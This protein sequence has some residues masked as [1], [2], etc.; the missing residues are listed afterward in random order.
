MV[1]GGQRRHGVRGAVERIRSGSGAPRVRPPGGPQPRLCGAHEAR[2]RRS[3]RQRGGPQGCGCAC[4]ARGDG[5][6]RDR[7]EGGQHVVRRGAPDRRGR[8]LPVSGSSGAPLEC[9]GAAGGGLMSCCRS[10]CV[11][12][13]C[14]RVYSRGRQWAPRSGEGLCGRG[15]RLQEEPRS[16]AGAEGDAEGGGVC[17]QG[18]ASLR[19]GAQS[20]RE[21]WGATHTIIEPL[22]LQGM[23]VGV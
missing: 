3:R 17:T 2:G 5:H 20:E 10:I 19:G 21:G 6:C 7:G 18:G 16:H 13:L 22:S 8:G 1:G 4:P 14:R 9:V 12:P 15:G 23:G 11:C